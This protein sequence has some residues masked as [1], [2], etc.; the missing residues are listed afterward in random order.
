VIN[1][2]DLSPEQKQLAATIGRAAVKSGIDPDFAIAQALAE[3]N[4]THFLSKEEAKEKGLNYTVDSD[5]N[6]VILSPKT[7]YGQAVGLMQILPST[8]ESYGYDKKDLLNP[9]KNVELYTK[10]MADNI[11]KYGTLDL[12]A[13]AYHQGHEPVDKFL[14]DDDLK[15]IG[16]IGKE[17]VRRI[18]QYYDF[19]GANQEA[20]DEP[21]EELTEGEK[22]SLER[23]K[24]KQD[25]V[26]T[27]DTPLQNPLSDIG[28]VTGPV[29]FG[30]QFMMNKATPKGE[31]YPSSPSVEDVERQF[32]PQF[33]SLEDELKSLGAAEEI[34]MSSGD[35]W[36]TKTVGSQGPGGEATTEAARNYRM[37]KSLEQ[38]GLTPKWRP[39][40]EG[41]I[42]PTNL[43]QE[44]Q[45]A[46]AA[47]MEAEARR[48][49]AERERIEQERERIDAEK[50]QAINKAMKNQ[51]V[52]NRIGM[53]AGQYMRTS[54]TLTGLTQATAGVF[55]DEARQRMDK[56]DILGAAI[57]GVKAV[58]AGI[59]GLPI[60]PRYGPLLRVKGYGQLGLGGGML[61]DEIRTRLGF[62]PEYK[63]YKPKP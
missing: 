28:F 29:A 35:K 49:Q 13:M 62:N 33:S 20:T 50:R 8:A 52:L 41:I 34:A 55:A 27:N 47:R 51:S 14:E 40:R 37:Q 18:G 19:T 12:A 3:S 26:G 56:G 24:A 25:E 60:P 22:L 45:Q 42:L 57:S 58:G 17:Y 23:A 46:E 31:R 6:Y 1:E 32:K 53:N 21:T 38:E 7:K 16:P 48:I 43:A 4:L 10:I 11:K 15:H 54:P 44:Q 39:N 30:T 2:E 59:G 63:D 36:S 5:G 9:I 61:A